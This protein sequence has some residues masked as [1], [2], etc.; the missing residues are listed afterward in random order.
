VKRNH[1]R[2]LWTGGISFYLDGVSFYHKFN[3]MWRKPSEGLS[4]Y[5]TAKGAHVGSGGRVVKFMV[6][7]SYEEGVVM[8]E[9][10]E[11][12]NGEFFKDFVLEHFPKTFRKSRKGRERRFLQDRDP[13]QNSVKAKAALSTVKAVKFDIPPRSPDLNPIE[14]LFHIVKEDLRLNAIE[15]D[16][17]YE[18]KSE[19]AQRVKIIFL[20][21]DRE[22]VDRII[23]SMNKRIDEVIRNKGRRLKY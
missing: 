10:Y 5:C 22:V 14:N 15:K 3:P 6:A 20:S 7:I 19:F 4:Q 21:T 18:T 17:T 12:L 16:I 11:H 9:E 8:Y 13:S 23:L 1:T 2:D